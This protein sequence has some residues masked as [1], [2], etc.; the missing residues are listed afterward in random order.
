MYKGIVV[1]RRRSDLT[2]PQFEEWFVGRHLEFSKS[3]PDIVRYTGSFTRAEAPRTEWEAPD[4]PPIDIVS[5]IWAADLE[6]MKRAYS[7]LATMGGP[8][9]SLAHTASR[10]AVIAEERVI[11]ER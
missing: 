5:E 11:F 9:D 2:A 4:R 8:D 10:I 3:C 7:Q 1:L 6:G